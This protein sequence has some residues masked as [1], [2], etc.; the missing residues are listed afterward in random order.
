MLL[1]LGVQQLLCLTDPCAV[2][3]QSSINNRYAFSKEKVFFFVI[4]HPKRKIL[5]LFDH[6]VFI[7]T[8][9]QN[10]LLYKIFF[11]MYKLLFFIQWC[12]K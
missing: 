7:Q 6:L 12:G 9:N 3:P 8:L 10:L 4:V 11:R 5:S 1:E 2:H